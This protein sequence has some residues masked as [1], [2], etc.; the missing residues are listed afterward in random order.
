MAHAHTDN[1]IGDNYQQDS[2]R[3]A[4]SLGFPIPS[5]MPTPAEVQQEA[6][7]RSTMILEGWEKLQEI[8]ERREDLLGKR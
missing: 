6:R 1:E 8:L 5:S 7:E 4:A 3:Q 2:F